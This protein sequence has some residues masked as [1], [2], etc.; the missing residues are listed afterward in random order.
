M[1][2]KIKHL[3]NY[4]YS[5]KVFFEPLTLRFKPKNN[6]H[7]K[8]ERFNLT[9]KPKPSG[10]TEST[11]LEDNEI[12]TIWFDG[13]HDELII[14]SS[15]IVEPLNKNPFNFIFTDS[16]FEKL[17]V[18]ITTENTLSPFI[19]TLSRSKGIKGFIKPILRRSKY[20]TLD[21]LFDL[22]NTVYNGFETIIRETGNPWTPL[23]TLSCRQG[24]CR[25][26]SVL[27]IECCRSVGLPSRFVTGYNEIDLNS[28]EKNLHAWA[29]VFI[30]GGGWIGYDPTLGLAVSDKHIAIS[31]SSNP[32]NTYPVSGSFRGTNATSVVKYKIDIIKCN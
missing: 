29:E 25:D 13:T 31:S 1:K 5:K 6:N 8:V 19:K 17:P 3:T 24:S 23:K 10:L 22:N 27:F 30:P 11:D 9:I 26:V 2:Y 14:N 21:F 28:E 12:A 15:S 32:L 4:K 20:K 16:S 7:Q 18:V